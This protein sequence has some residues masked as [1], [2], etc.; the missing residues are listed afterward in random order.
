VPIDEYGDQIGHHI[1][2]AIGGV[3]KVIEAWPGAVI[4]HEQGLYPSEEASLRVA[5]LGQL[6]KVGKV[7]DAIVR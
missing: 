1:M 5:D 3:G 7:V 2:P 4:F 6:S